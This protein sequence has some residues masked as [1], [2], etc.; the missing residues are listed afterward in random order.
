MAERENALDETPPFAVR[1]RTRTY[2]DAKMKWLL[3]S[4]VSW[5]TGLIVFYRFDWRLG[6][7]QTCFVFAAYC[8]LN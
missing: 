6:V 5:I 2:G 8:N 1:D 7:A 4:F 3:L